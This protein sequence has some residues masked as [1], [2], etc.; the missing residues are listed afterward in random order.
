MLVRNQ[1][2]LPVLTPQ[3]LLDVELVVVESEDALLNSFVVLPHQDL[4]IAADHRQT[5]LHARPLE[6]LYLV[7][8]R[9]DRN[10]LQLTDIPDPH[11]VGH[12]V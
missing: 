7:A 5:P 4:I 3:H 8:A 10:Q 6:R 11:G 2:L 12:V 9:N 1:D